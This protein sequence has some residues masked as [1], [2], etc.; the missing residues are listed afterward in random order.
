M[1]GPLRPGDHVAV[2]TE[3]G[4]IEHDGVVVPGRGH[5]GLDVI[6]F[7]NPTGRR[8]DVTRTTLDRFAG[9]Q[10]VRVIHDRTVSRE[11]AVANAEHAEI[12]GAG[13]YNLLVNNCQDFATACVTGGGGHSRQRETATRVMSLATGP[14]APMTYVGLRMMQ[15]A[16]KKAL[17]G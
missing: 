14:A 17:G 1:T 5:A 9:G 3:Y 6:Q 13:S 16:G 11:Q 10:A 2:P 15:Y 7:S 4:G 12:H 8:S